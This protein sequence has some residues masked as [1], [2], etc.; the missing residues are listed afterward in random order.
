MIATSRRTTS[1]LIGLL[2]VFTH[3]ACD[4][5]KGQKSGDVQTPDGGA[6]SDA[7]T[8]STAGKGGSS[9]DKAGSE[10][11]E[12]AGSGGTS[13]MDNA[14]EGGAGAAAGSGG[15]AE[16]AAGKGGSAAAGSGG[17]AGTAGQAA[18]TG[19][20]GGRGTAGR[21]AGGRGGYAGRGAGGRGG[22]GEGGTSAG[23]SG[24]G[25]GGNAAAGSGG[26]AGAG[27]GGAGGTSEAGSGGTSGGKRCGTRGGVECNEGEYCNFEPDPNCGN[28]DRGGQCQAKTE[29]C[30]DL[31]A[32]VC[33]CDNRT[34]SNACVAHRDGVSVKNDGMCGPAECVAAGG[35]IATSNGA[36]PADCAD[37]ED[38]WSITGGRES[39]RCC[40]PK[41]RGKTCAG[42][43]NLQC[44]DGEFCNFEPPGGQG[45]DGTVA[46]NGG[47]CEAV[48]KD[49]G[50]ETQ[51]V[52]SCEHHSFA[53]ICAAHAS[54]EAK[55]HDGGCTQADCEAVGGHVVYGFGPPAMCA[56]NET[57]FTWIVGDN[58]QL[59]IEG[60]SCCVPK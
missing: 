6:T 60:A 9:S 47:V 10:A 29:I 50:D 40:I 36:N 33:G 28:T 45:C 55:L 27:A 15:A 46:D 7:A 53:G 25:A 4:S 18:G 23:H 1:Y 44:A 39:A 35:Y 20:T 31:Y 24:A 17:A 41:P 57:E 30:D 59:P 16:S 38:S 13:S 52:C 26:R 42:I 11:G 2:A 58:G 34:Y 22:A 19:G 21:G 48:P 49:C 51:P 12:S 14:G 43:A 32:P 54:G 5:S 3:V 8:G 37:G 56:A